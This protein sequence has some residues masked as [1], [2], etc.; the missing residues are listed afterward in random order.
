MEWKE[1]VTDKMVTEQGWRHDDYPISSVEEDAQWEVYDE[2]AWDRAAEKS[3]ELEAGKVTLKIPSLT[4]AEGSNMRATASKRVTVREL[5]RQGW[6]FVQAV[7]DYKAIL[8]GTYLSYEKGD[9]M[10]VIHR[11]SDGRLTAHLGS[12]EIVRH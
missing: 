11:D 10:K 1:T 8:R 4:R 7:T 9:V 6:E 12:A 5:M 2:A 3:K